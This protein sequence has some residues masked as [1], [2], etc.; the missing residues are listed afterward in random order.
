MAHFGDIFFANMG[1]GGGQNRFHTQTGLCKCGWVWSSLILPPFLKRLACSGLLRPPL[2][3]GRRFSEGGPKTELGNW[4]PI[5]KL[6]NRKAQ[7]LKN[8]PQHTK[9]R[10]PE[11]PLQIPPGI[12]KK[13]W[14]FRGIFRISCCRG[15]LDVRV[16]FLTYFGGFGG[17]LLCSWVVGC[18][19]W[20]SRELRKKAFV[21][22]HSLLCLSSKRR[23]GGSFDQGWLLKIASRGSCGYTGICSI[24]KECNFKKF[25]TTL[26]PTEPLLALW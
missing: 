3:V 25:S 26:F 1:G 12:P 23:K 14:Y 8:T 7:K 17:F 9:K 21:F 19:L 24:L 10:L 15:N 13:S 2:C 16:V 18:Q 22:T 20:K 6:Q 4:E 5:D 11:I